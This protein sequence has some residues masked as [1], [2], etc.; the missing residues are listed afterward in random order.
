[1]LSAKEKKRLFQA[2]PPCLREK[3]GGLNMHVSWA[4]FCEGAGTVGAQVTDDFTDQD[5]L[6][7]TLTLPPLLWE[8]ESAFSLSIKTRGNLAK[9]V[10][11]WGS[12]FLF[13][14]GRESFEYFAA[15]TQALKVF[16]VRQFPAVS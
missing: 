1:M 11:F 4:C 8:V 6:G 15:L 2:R 5:A 14:A 16:V 3:A 10:P 13:N 12:G 9:L 7:L